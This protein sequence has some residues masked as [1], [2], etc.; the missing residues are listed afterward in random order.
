[1]LLFIDQPKHIRVLRASPDASGAMKRERLGL[2]LKSTLEPSPELSAAILPD[3]TEEI[4][5]A[6]AMY[7]KA[8]TS[9]RQT[10]ALTFPE[11]M[12]EVVEY[13]REDASE[14]EKRII[15]AALMEA[16]RMVRKSARESDQTASE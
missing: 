4:A 10:A 13:L 3:E 8:A 11:T 14:N 2:V 15:I 16:V 6:I 9:K 7:R 1:M 5:E 12:R